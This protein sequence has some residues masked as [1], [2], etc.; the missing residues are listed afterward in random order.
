[1]M[2]SVTL[3]YIYDPDANFLDESNSGLYIFEYL[4][5]DSSHF[6]SINCGD[7]FKSKHINT[8]AY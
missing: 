3:A 7:M 2:L 4:E 8:H 5:L 6:F 1:M